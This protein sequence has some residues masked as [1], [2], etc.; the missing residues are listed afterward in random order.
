MTD[1]PRGQ[2]PE[3][4][5]VAKAAGLPAA[6]RHRTVAPGPARC[7]IAG[8]DRSPDAARCQSSRGSAQPEGSGR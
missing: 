5:D 1:Q 4:L 6:R 3:L 7:G 8:T 2:S